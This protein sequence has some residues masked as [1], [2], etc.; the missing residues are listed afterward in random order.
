MKIIDNYIYFTSQNRYNKDIQDEFRVDIY[1]FT[2]ECKPE[3]EWVVNEN[4]HHWM[5]STIINKE[6]IITLKS[7]MRAIKIHKYQNGNK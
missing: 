7:V 4:I 5:K 3:L 2:F 1:N 6:I